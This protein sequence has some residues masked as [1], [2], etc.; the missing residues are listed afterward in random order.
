V[1]EKTATAVA[2][3]GRVKSAI[4]PPVLSMAG[5]RTLAW[6]AFSRNAVGLY[7]FDSR[8]WGMGPIPR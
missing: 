2:R 3:A 4:A 5:E 8:L 1:V 7:Q 6:S